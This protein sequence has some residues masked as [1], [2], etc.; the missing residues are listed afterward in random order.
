MSETET[1]APVD[2]GVVDTGGPASTP[3]DA[4]AT[5]ETTETPEQQGERGGTDKRLAR[6][7][8]RIT[9]GEAERAQLRAELD[10]M[11]RG[12]QVPQQPVEIPPEWQPILEREVEARAAA[13]E[14]QRGVQAFHAAG[15][16][17]HADWP[18]L[19]QSLIDMG[20]DP[21]FS[22][23]LVETPN[24]H[25]IAAALADEPEELERIAA[26][27]TERARAIELG[28][29]AARFETRPAPPKRAAVSRAPEP[30]RPVTGSVNAQPDPYRMTAQQN[31]DYYS[32]LDMESRKRR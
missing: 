21:G 2:D 12:E 11:R 9:A 23:I 24:G 7:T 20:A 28:K 29:F 5:T 6:L 4:P 14:A 16:A 15:R 13:R 30:V 32:R 26:L 25:K 31:V 18:Q 19:C 27:R 1:T 10:R 8:A 22:Q 17:E 3:P